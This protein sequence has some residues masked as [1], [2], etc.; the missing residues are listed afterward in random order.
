MAKIKATHRLL[1]PHNVLFDARRHFVKGHATGDRIQL[2]PGAQMIPTEL[3][4]QNLP[5]RFENLGR[6]A[7]PQEK[8]L[9]KEGADG[10]K[11]AGDGA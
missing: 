4:L 9:N 5:D 3:E 11:A 1:H 10:E 8:E 2:K 6:P 7:T